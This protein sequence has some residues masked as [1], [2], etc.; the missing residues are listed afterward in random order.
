MLAAIHDAPTGLRLGAERA[1]LKTLDGSCETPIAGLAVPED[2]T[3][4]LRGEILRPDGSEA[5]D[6]ALRG[7][8]SDGADLGQALAEQLLGQ[9]PKG[10]FSWKG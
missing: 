6:G 7:V 8:A 5:I 9:A 4:H 2:G 3:L 1:Y 10:F